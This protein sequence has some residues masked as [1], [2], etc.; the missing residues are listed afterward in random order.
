MSLPAVKVIV[1]NGGLGR[2]AITEDGV[3]GLIVTGKA[4]SGKLELNKPYTLTSTRDMVALGI[5]AENN[6]LAY[7]DITAFYA[8]AGEGSELHLAVVAEATTLTSMCTL[9]PASPLCRLI[10]SAGGRIRLVGVNKIAPAEYT[11]EAAA[12]IDGDTVTAVS[13]A[14]KTAES[15]AKNIAPFRVFVAAPAFD[16]TSET[17]FKPREAGSNRAA[18]V[19]ASDDAVGKSAAVG[20]VLGRAAKAEPQQSLG[21]VKDGAIAAKLWLTNGKS[22]AE[23]ASLSATLHDAGYIIPISYPTKNGA[24]LNGNPMASSIEDDYS[25]LNLGRVIDKA[26]IVAYNTYI[27]E[28]M[29][30]ILISED[31]T[32]APGVCVS[33][34]GMLE[35]AVTASMNGQISSFNVSIDSKQNVLSSGVLEIQCK[36]VPLATLQQIVVNLA[37]ENPALKTA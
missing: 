32:L 17:L 18:V 23:M 2:T 9:E 7:K 12:G 10:D 8:A 3:A 13:E 35:N 15:Y 26:M 11:S 4:V 21:R 33:Y 16:E 34:S 24:Y 27:S 31:G 5:T 36:I 20:M 28:I 30:N 19:L 1:G 37:F 6:F 14:H 22:F 25:E 29:D